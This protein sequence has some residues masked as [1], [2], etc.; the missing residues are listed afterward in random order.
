MLPG[1]LNPPAA[2]TDKA[3][4]NNESETIKAV[5]RPP[6]KRPKSTCFFIAISFPRTH[7]LAH[8]ADWLLVTSG[9]PSEARAALYDR[10]RTPQRQFAYT[11]YRCDARTTVLFPGVTRGDNQCGVESPSPKKSVLKHCNR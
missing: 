7:L 8:W 11:S 9:T 4:S 1:L 3:P 6:R 2:S 10:F 5:R